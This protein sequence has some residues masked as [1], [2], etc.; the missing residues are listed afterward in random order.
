MILVIT[1]ITTMCGT[2]VFESCRQARDHVNHAT[3]MEQQQPQE[4]VPLT[5]RA[6]I[7]AWA[8]GSA[9]LDQLHSAVVTCQPA[10]AAAAGM[11]AGFPW[12]NSI[13][14]VYNKLKQCQSNEYLVNFIVSR[15]N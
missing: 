11:Q 3:A 8:A 2:Y 6:I 10:Q 1:F 7:L 15:F 9:V 13:C 4:G 14:A 12:D 5:R